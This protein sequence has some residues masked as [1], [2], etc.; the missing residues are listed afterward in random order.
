[1]ARL[2][3]SSTVCLI[4]VGLP[5]LGH[6]SI[7]FEYE[8]GASKSTMPPW[9]ALTPPTDRPAFECRFRM[10]TPFTTIC[11]LAGRVRRTCPC[12]P[13]S[14]PATTTT[15]SPG[16]RSSQRRLGWG[17][18]VNISEDLRREGHDLHEVLLAQFARHRTEDPGPSGVVLLSEHDRRVLVEADDRAV[19]PPVLLGDA[20]H[21]GL[22]DLALL[23]LTARLRGLDRG[24]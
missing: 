13:L 2:P 8:S 3:F 4:R 15:V 7:T 5:Q 11:P 24:R 10:F 14:L 23:D 17:L 18:L 1:M 16:A 6:T 19:G 9:I 22:H 20:H 12:L 21:H